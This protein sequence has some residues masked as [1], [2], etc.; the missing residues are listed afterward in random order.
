VPGTFP[1]KL[2]KELIEVCEFK[3][4]VFKDHVW[5]QTVYYIIIKYLKDKDI[6][7]ELSL[8]RL[9]WKAWFAAYAIRTAHMTDLQAEQHID[10]TVKEFFKHRSIL[11]KSL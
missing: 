2:R 3:N 10:E 5:V 9:L 8:L 4:F 6:K 11:V 7:K 1:S